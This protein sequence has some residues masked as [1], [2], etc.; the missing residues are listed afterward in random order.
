[1]RKQLLCLMP[2][3][4]PLNDVRDISGLLRA[5]ANAVVFR[6]P[7]A[8]PGQQRAAQFELNPRIAGQCGHP[9]KHGC[10]KRGAKNSPGMSPT[11]KTLAG[12][13]LHRTDEL[14]TGQGF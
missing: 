4:R 12:Q 5:F 8:C 6:S 9:S 1:M 7:G 13:S 10:L 14:K 11:V 2:W 3:P